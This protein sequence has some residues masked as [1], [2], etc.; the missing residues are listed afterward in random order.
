MMLRTIISLL[1]ALMLALT[2]QAM[3][4]ARGA[5]A[6]TG[7]M[8]LCSGTDAITVYVD[9]E[10][11]PTASPH[12]CPDCMVIAAGCAVPFGVTAVDAVAS[13]DLSLEIVPQ[14]RAATKRQG[15]HSR[16]PPLFV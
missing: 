7:Q 10:G 9:A 8:E 3:A 5:A 12:I 16:A 15:P 13:S 1:L 14:V 2:S 6:A 11:A 4:V